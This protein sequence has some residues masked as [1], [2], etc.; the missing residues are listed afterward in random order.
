MLFYKSNNTYNL[1]M[2]IGVGNYFCYLN[3]LVI[4][5]SYNHFPYI[6]ICNKFIPSVVAF[7]PYLTELI[8]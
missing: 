8:D 4:L 1:E 5:K 3:V 6:Y 2:F 7:N